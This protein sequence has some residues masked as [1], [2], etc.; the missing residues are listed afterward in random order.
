MSWAFIREAEPG[1]ELLE[2]ACWEGERDLQNILDAG[3]KQYYYG[4]TWRGR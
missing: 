1:F 3:D 2:E 4:E